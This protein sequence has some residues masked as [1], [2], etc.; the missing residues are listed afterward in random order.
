MQGKL[1]RPPNHI[2]VEEEVFTFVYEFISVYPAL[3]GRI[4]LI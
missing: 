4:Q 1:K 3:L 2:F